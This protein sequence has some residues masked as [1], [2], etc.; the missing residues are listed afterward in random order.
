[1]LVQPSKTESLMHMQIVS[2]TVC[3]NAGKMFITSD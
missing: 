2:A 3:I 1:M